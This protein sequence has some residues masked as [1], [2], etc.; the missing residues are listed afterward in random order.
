VRG[1]GLAQDGCFLS[2]EFFFGQ[3]AFVEQLFELAELVYFRLCGVGLGCFGCGPDSGIGLAWGRGVGRRWGIRWRGI[4]GLLGIVRGGGGS[5]EGPDEGADPT[6]HGPAQEKIKSEDA[7]GAAMLTDDGDDCGQEIGEK[8]KDK[9]A[10]AERSGKKREKVVVIDHG[11]KSL[12]A[13]ALGGCRAKYNSFWAGGHLEKRNFLF[14]FVT[15]STT[16]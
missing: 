1:G 5:G 13:A 14:Y 7:T 2:V 10:Q 8:E 3:D 4:V 15:Q 12:W 9:E 16:K 11:R 6:D